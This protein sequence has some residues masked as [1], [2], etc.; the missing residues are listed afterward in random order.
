MD[1]LN[2]ETA[3]LTFTPWI[4]HLKKHILLLWIRKWTHKWNDPSLNKYHGNTQ[5]RMINEKHT[6]KEAIT[7]INYNSR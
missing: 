7:E 1:M 2:Y 3:F 6:E 5:F 4:I